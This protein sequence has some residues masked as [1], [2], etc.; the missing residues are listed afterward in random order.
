MEAE[1]QAVGA[2]LA[3]RFEAARERGEV[4]GARVL[5]NLHGVAAAEGNGRAALAGQGA[6]AA[7]AADLAVGAR[8]ARGDPERSPVQRS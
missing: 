1:Q 6:E 2:N 4:D 8:G 5:V 3:E 7:L